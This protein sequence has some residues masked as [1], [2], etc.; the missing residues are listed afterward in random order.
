MND[1][2][3]S[4]E[5]ENPG[6]LEDTANSLQP[7]NQHVSIHGHEGIGKLFS[8]LAKARAEF[9]A[10]KK[11]G[12]V[13]I[14]F[15]SRKT[16]EWVDNSFAYSTIDDLNAATKDALAKH[17]VAVFQSLAGHK[18]TYYITTIVG[19]GGSY[20]KSV[21]EFTSA[22]LGNSTLSQVQ[23]LGSATTYMRRYALQAALCHAGDIDED[24]PTGAER[25]ADIPNSQPGQ[26][27]QQEKP[28]AKP[29]PKPQTL[30][31]SHMRALAIPDA[32]LPD[33]L[34]SCGVDPQRFK[35]DDKYAEQALGVLKQKES[36][37]ARFS[38]NGGSNP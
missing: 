7:T 8:G 25:D 34:K 23:Q 10:V 18:G 22:I 36:E 35:N 5:K 24:D 28:E 1:F 13:K 31:I 33:A 14:R 37:L 21:I 30:V 4:F 11:S 27:Q 20:I 17:E 9:G 3:K 15:K 6:A 29:K 12:E 26:G 32:A 19:C 16:N 38:V 2:T